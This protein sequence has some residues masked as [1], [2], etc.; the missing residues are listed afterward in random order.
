MIDVH[1]NVDI[2]D[3]AATQAGDGD[4]RGG[5]ACRSGDVVVVRYGDDRVIAVPG[6]RLHQGGVRDRLRARVSETQQRG[7][8]L[9]HVRSLEAD[10]R[11]EAGGRI[12]GGEALGQQV[13]LDPGIA[14]TARGAAKRGQFLAGEDVA[15]ETVGVGPGGDHGH[16]GV[17]PAASGVDVAEPVEDE[18][19]HAGAGVE[20]AAVEG[21][22]LAVG[23]VQL[24]GIDGPWQVVLR[25]AVDQ[26][27]RGDAAGGIDPDEGQVID[28][29][30][31]DIA[32]AAGRAAQRCG[33]DQIGG[34]GGD[35]AQA[36]QPHRSQQDIG[37][38]TAIEQ[39]IA[40]AVA[41][42]VADVQH[43]RQLLAGGHALDGHRLAEQRIAV[44]GTGTG[45]VQ[46]DV[47]LA[48]RR[49]DQRRG[50]FIAV[51][52]GRQAAAGLT[53]S[54]V[55]AELGA[56]VDVDAPA[57]QL[58][59]GHVPV[60]IQVDITHALEEVGGL[61]GHA[62]V[63]ERGLER[64]EYRVRLPVLVEDAAATQVQLAHAVQD[65]AAILGQ[66]RAGL[67]RHGGEIRHLS[68]GG[69]EVE[70]A[71]DPDIAAPAHGI[72]AGQQIRQVDDRGR[73]GAGRSALDQVGVA[74]TGQDDVGPAIA[75]DIAPQD[76]VDGQ[77]AGIDDG[78]QPAV[79]DQ[80]AHHD[81]IAQVMAANELGAGL[82]EQDVQQA[83]VHV[84]G[85]QIPGAGAIIVADAADDQVVGKAGVAA[86]GN[87]VQRHDHHV[88]DVEAFE[89]IVVGIHRIEDEA[90]QHVVA[91]VGVE[92][93]AG[94]LPGA[95]R[96]EQT[97]ALVVRQRVP[98]GAVVGADLHPGLV[99]AGQG[100]GLE[101]VI[102]VQTG[103]GDAGQVDGR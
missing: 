19:A 10:L 94:R 33:I 25:P 89:G 6:A 27:D 47:L 88:I 23:R 74:V 78:A 48:G 34:L 3:Q 57:E 97:A 28:A 49:R 100:L 93:H 13:Q 22:D 29:V 20:L 51:V 92:V 55:G 95:G 24:A 54:L 99:E 82:T 103:R 56:G 60:T 62:G 81:R 83:V 85:G 26:R 77:I 102:E 38:L 9:G 30:T 45:D 90:D 1:L 52:P 73:R 8:A 14:G 75:V 71:L 32:H 98:V 40:V 69:V 64:F 44:A 72:T 11:R 37:L 53:G 84:I 35:V 58:G 96:I 12:L 15:V 50:H 31:V 43:V 4:G 61:A 7:K 39:V 80:I 21:N 16:V 59:H 65:T 66:P 86:L 68:G 63:V 5:H 76:V 17:H 91:D 41:A 46:T 101:V 36:L 2:G 18:Q 79:I 87:L 70:H 67:Q 42:E